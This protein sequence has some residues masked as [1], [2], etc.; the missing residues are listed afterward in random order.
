MASVEDSIGRAFRKALGV[1]AV[2]AAATALAGAGWAL[3]SPEQADAHEGDSDPSFY[4]FCLN[5]TSNKLINNTPTGAACGANEIPLHIPKSTAIGPTGA[6]GVSGV[7]GVS[8]I[9]GVSG[10]SGAQGPQGPTGH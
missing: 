7:S 9:S 5:T 1:T 10:V 8:G 4:H 2:I 6:S 3:Q